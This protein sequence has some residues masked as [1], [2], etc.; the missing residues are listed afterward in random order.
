MDLKAIKLD[1]I[2]DN[3]VKTTHFRND[4]L[5]TWTVSETC[6][7]TTDMVIINS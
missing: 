3:L 4:E 6:T 1:I 7:R 2:W 5:E